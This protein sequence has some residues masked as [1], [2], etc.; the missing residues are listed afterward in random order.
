MDFNTCASASEIRIQ[1]LH[2]P[3]GFR[4]PHPS[5]P[6]PQPQITV[7]LTT[8]EYDGTFLSVCGYR[9]AKMYLCFPVHR[10]VYFHMCPIV[11]L[12]HEH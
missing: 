11:N 2:Q 9:A 10:C 12:Y 5:Q 8:K 3:Q 4:V 7:S 1:W 6:L